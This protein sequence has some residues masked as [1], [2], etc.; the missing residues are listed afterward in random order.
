MADRPEVQLVIAGGG[1][2]DN[3]YE[4]ELRRCED[5][6]I[7]FTGPADRE[8]M[9]ELFTHAKLFVLPSEI[10]GMSIVLLEAMHMG[11]PVLVSDIPEN[12]CVVEDAGA[13]FRAGDVESLQSELRALLDAD[14]VCVGERDGEEREP[15]DR[16][17]E[18]GR[19]YQ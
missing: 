13:T 17:G 7:I 4:R 18:C 10:E 15:C 12:R 14:R 11:V 2:L 8:L 6:R 9:S 19:T 5:P 1:R 16:R 3:S